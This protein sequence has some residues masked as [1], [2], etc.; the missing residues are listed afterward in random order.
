MKRKIQIILAGLM[1]CVLMA[2]GATAVSAAAAGCVEVSYEGI[3][4]YGKADDL[5]S[6]INQYRRTSGRSML[7]TDAQLQ[8]AA[9]YRAAEIALLYNQSRPDGSSYLTLLPEEYQD[10]KQEIAAGAKNASALI[11]VLKASDASKANMLSS[12]YNSLGVGCYNNNGTYTWVLL[13]SGSGKAGETSREI[14]SVN[15]TTDILSA[16]LNLQVVGATD[17]EDHL[18][19]EKTGYLKVSNTNIM[20]PSQTPLVV[21][22]H[23]DCFEWELSSP[24]LVQKQTV[25]QESCVIK[26][27]KEGRFY[28]TI[29]QGGIFSKAYPISIEGVTSLDTPKL[30]SV[31]ALSAKSAELTWKSVPYAAGY[32]IY[33]KEYYGSYKAV[34]DVS[35]STTTYADAFPKVA[36]TYLYTVRAYY[37]GANGIVWSNFESGLEFCL[38][39]E[40]PKVHAPVILAN[41]NVQIKWDKVPYASGY[42]V[43]RKKEGDNWGRI[44]TVGA[45]VTS[46]LDEA[47]LADINT[48]YTVRAYFNCNSGIEWSNYVENI[49]I[50]LQLPTA[51]LGIAVDEAYNQIRVTWERESWADGYYVYRKTQGGKW[52]LI[53]T[54]GSTLSYLD[55]KAEPGIKYIYTV[56]AFRKSGSGVIRGGF[57]A[58]G[59]TATTS[60]GTVKLK[61]IA[62]NGYD[63]INV[64]W[65]AEDGATGYRVYRKEKG[66]NWKALKTVTSGVTS[67]K[68]TTGV[69]GKQYYYTV[70]A[71]R[72]TTAGNAWGSF[73]TPGLTATIPNLAVVKLG[74]ID[75]SSYDSIILTW[76]KVEGAT[77]Y[78]I[79]RKVA[80]GKWV[81]LGNVTSTVVSYA[82]RTAEIGKQYYYT[83]RA[84]RKVTGGYAWGGYQTPGLTATIPNLDTVE[85]KNI[86]VKSYNRIDI[87]WNKV[88]GAT[89]YRVFRKEKGG[90]WKGLKN[91]SA[92]TTAFSD[93]TAVPGTQYYYTVRAY[94][95][96]AAGNV[97]GNFQSPGLA[98]TAALS[99]G[100]ITAASSGAANTVTLKWAPVEGT[101][102]Y[103]IYAKEG[104]DGK[105][106]HVYSTNPDVTTFTHKNLES[107]VTYY[108]KVRSYRTIAVNPNKYSFGA[109]SDEMP[110]IVK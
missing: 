88:G 28:A 51:K 42:R 97:W 53:A 8:E 103:Q 19:I 87:S 66:G 109:F 47:P 101:T 61:D 17:N 82:D 52:N 12:N 20:A 30:V 46:V 14:K 2:L 92:S 15:T 56:R 108:Y 34:K 10:T 78:R 59:V 74:T 22:L 86:Q 94:R 100:N 69:I 21:P 18:M 91:V 81:G 55:K 24:E 13:Y 68:D 96:T 25:N 60:M 83:V 70:R 93:T 54:V 57:D 16:Y 95:K 36:Q 63:S 72:K 4:D 23:A 65:N 84:F 89:G 31:E 40:T 85:L 67:Y 107:G 43:Y 32:R 90:N 79:Y 45:S 38:D 41:K 48:L 58:A 98:A 104:A 44:A 71:Y 102:V 35:A 80:G 73:Q 39:A 26:T 77:G 6:L 3:N 106:I 50:R 76:N 62:L 99:K 75:A 27:L 29:S 7:V 37:K 5:L 64:S 110:V 1:L 105:Y 11:K 33:R 9:M 49:S